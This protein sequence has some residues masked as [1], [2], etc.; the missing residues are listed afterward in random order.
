MIRLADWVLVVSLLASGCGGERRE[1]DAVAQAH[2]LRA[3]VGT[4]D[5]GAGRIG[6]AALTTIRADQ[7]QGPDAAWALMLMRNGAPISQTLSYAASATY[8]VSSWLDVAPLANATY[9]VVAT[10]G[11][12]TLTASAILGEGSPLA[13]PAPVLALD[14]TRLDWPVVTGATAYACVL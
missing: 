14:G 1:P 5:D 13:L 12:E 4:Y 11:A 8:S 6:I 9:D 10:D 2:A 3:T 7:G